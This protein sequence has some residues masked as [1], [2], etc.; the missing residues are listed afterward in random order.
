M[1]H[2]RRASPLCG[3][4]APRAQGAMFAIVGKF[5]SSIS[6]SRDSRGF[7]GQ[8]IRTSVLSVQL[9]GWVGIMRQGGASSENGA[10][11][12]AAPSPAASAIHF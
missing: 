5:G 9:C 8:W 12:F 3:C 10:R 4:V 2:V 1:S 11:S 7:E 6:A